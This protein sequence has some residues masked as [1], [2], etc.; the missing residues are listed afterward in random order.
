MRVTGK[1]LLN[2][3]WECRVQMNLREFKLLFILLNLV[4]FAT[5]TFPSTRD[6]DACPCCFLGGGGAGAGSANS[7][8]FVIPL[9]RTILIFEGPSWSHNRGS[10]HVEHVPLHLHKAS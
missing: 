9:R 7:S 3:C 8:G 6:W 4:V 10:P 1:Y 5:S 2:D